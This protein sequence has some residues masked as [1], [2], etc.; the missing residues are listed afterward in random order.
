[1]KDAVFIMP[2][3]ALLDKVVNLI[4]EI[5]MEDR[6]TIRTI[7]RAFLV[8]RFFRFSTTC[9]KTRDLTSLSSACG[10]SRIFDA[11]AGRLNPIVYRKNTAHDHTALRPDSLSIGQTRSA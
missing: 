2:N 10:S 9:R 4:D 3:A 11:C 5:Q 1:M 6:D 8:S 7:R